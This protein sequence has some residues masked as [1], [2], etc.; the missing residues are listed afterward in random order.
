MY[1]CLNFWWSLFRNFFCLFFN[2]FTKLE[3]F[4][5]KSIYRKYRFENHKVEFTEY[6]QKIMRVKYFTMLMAFNVSNSIFIKTYHQKIKKKSF[7][8]KISR[9]INEW[10]KQFT[11]F[12]IYMNAY[13]RGARTV[14]LGPFPNNITNWKKII[15]GILFRLIATISQNFKAFWNFSLMIINLTNFLSFTIMAA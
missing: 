13:Q 6:L 7:S 4:F 2:K 9:I 14:I 10:K 3:N 1:S 15:Y 11:K 8:R 12:I 5:V